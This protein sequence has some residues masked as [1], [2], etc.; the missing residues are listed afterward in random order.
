MDLYFNESGDI[1]PSHNGDI[2]MTQTNWRDDVQAA[3]IRVMTDQEDF[4]LYPDLGATLSRLYG[5]PQSPE[6]GEEG[7]ALIIS[8]L[9]KDGRFEG[10]GMNVKAV[11]TSASSIRFDIRLFSGNRRRI[12]MSVEQDLGLNPGGA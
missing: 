4:T 8:A 7:K 3:Y 5:M 11:P 1:E 12:A 2:A 9:K 6:T 10:Y